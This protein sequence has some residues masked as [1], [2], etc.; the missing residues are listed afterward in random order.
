MSCHP[1]SNLTS[2]EPSDPSSSSSASSLPA[3]ES[4]FTDSVAEEEGHVC[5]LAI[6]SLPEA[7]LRALMAKLAIEPPFQRAIARE[8]HLRTRSKGKTQHPAPLDAVCANCQQIY[9]DTVQTGHCTFHPGH[10]QDDVYEFVSHTPEGRELKIQ[11]TLPMWTCC[12]EAPQ[13]PGCAEAASHRW[14]TESE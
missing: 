8:L 4:S 2:P 7:E 5:C 3:S 12:A 14:R 6:A 9:R 10:L 11:R 1:S 13:M